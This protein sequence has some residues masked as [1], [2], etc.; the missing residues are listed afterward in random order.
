MVGSNI[1]SWDTDTAN[2]VSYTWKSKPFHSPSPTNLGVVQVLADSYPVTF[3]L[4]VDG[5]SKFL[6]SVVSENPQH[7]P[8]GYL[9]RSHEVTITGTNDVY[10]CIAASTILELSSV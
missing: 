8:S 6:G 2:K 7:L 9:G 1:V 4:T 10:E 3:E 5:T